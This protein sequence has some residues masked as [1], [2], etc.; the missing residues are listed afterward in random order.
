MKEKRLKLENRL[1]TTLKA[2]SIL[3][4]PNTPHQ[5]IYDNMKEFCQ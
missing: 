5:S 4:S 3:F 1:S 2:S